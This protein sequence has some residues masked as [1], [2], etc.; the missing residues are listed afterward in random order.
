MSPEGDLTAAGAPE[1]LQTGLLP[2]PAP[3][4]S[5]PGK[6]LYFLWRPG[7]VLLLLGGGILEVEE[8]GAPGWDHCEV[9]GSF[10]ANK[11]LL[12]LEKEN[13]QAS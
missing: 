8:C 7:G 12:F 9:H 6:S 11:S 10:K 5:M 1:E 3:V 2:F 13:L 4:Q